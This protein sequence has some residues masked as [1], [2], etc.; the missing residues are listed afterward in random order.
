MSNDDGGPGGM[1]YWPP[2]S[3]ARPRHRALREHEHMEMLV[4]DRKRQ[5]LGKN[6]DVP[7]ERRRRR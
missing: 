1:R 6:G 5:T 3:L 7:D 2:N 4:S